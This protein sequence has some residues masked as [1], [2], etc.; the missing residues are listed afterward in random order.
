MQRDRGY[1]EQTAR[2]IDE[3]IRRII[4]ESL[5]KTRHILETRRK[6]LVALA[7]RLIE[8]ETID[9]DELKAVVEA[10]S[11]SPLIVPGT[12]AARSG[13]RGQGSGAREP[14]SGDKEPGDGRPACG[15]A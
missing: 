3:E 7:E 8:K 12:E 4:N 9:T 13:D 2:E 11:P 14:G 10:N 6:A 15:L 1:S 5:E